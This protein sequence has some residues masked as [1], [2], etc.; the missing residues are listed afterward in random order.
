MTVLIKYA[1]AHLMAG[2]VLHAVFQHV[3]KSRYTRAEL[4]Q[5]LVFRT[6]LWPV[7]LYFFTTIMMRLI[8]TLI[9]VARLRR[10]TKQQREK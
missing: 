2:V 5:L 1:I 4:L 7:S 3:D 10:A 6:F 9:H 8:P